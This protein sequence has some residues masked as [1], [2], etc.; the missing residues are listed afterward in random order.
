MSLELIKETI[1]FNQ[2]IGE[3]TVQTI[4]E[5]DIIVP[6]AKP[7]MSRVLLMDGD[8][9]IEDVEVVKDRVVLKGFIYFKI[10]Y[11]TEDPEDCVKS[12]NTKSN[13]TYGMDIIG[14]KPG[15]N[16][17][18]KCDIEHI[19]YDILNSRK[20]SARSIV[21][22]DCKVSNQVEQDIAYDVGGV[23]GVQV[24]RESR[25]ISSY[26]GDNR[27]SF[28]VIE[29]M[30]VPSGKPAIREILR[31]DI[32]ING[33]DYRLTDNK[34]VA[35]GELSVST[36]Y[37]GDDE[38]RSIQFMEHEVPFSQF[39]DL[40]DINEDSWCELDYRIVDFQFEPSE[41]SDG[42]LRIMDGEI[43]LSIS[44]SGYRKTDIDIITD[45][46]SLHSRMS[47]EM[48]DLNLEEVAAENRSQIII[49]DE[50]ELDGDNPQMSE[51]FNVLCRPVL[52]EFKVLEDQI[53]I[54]GLTANNV[55]YLADSAEQPVSC[56]QQE[57][58]FRQVIDAAGVAPGMKCDI[59]MELEH[60]NYSMVSA[61]RVE[62][63]LVVNVYIKSLRPV[64]IPVIIRV[65]EQPADDSR[66][67]A[68]P[69]IIV[70]FS[71]PGDTLWKI[72]KRYYTTIDDIR[73]INDVESDKLAPG[74]QIIITARR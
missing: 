63:R 9:F 66:I 47:L 11:G 15:M 16:C 65:G 74:Q 22:L 44:V 72:A 49:K 28:K 5:S 12:I 1:K 60:C 73:N 45:A 51:I 48:E 67:A 54:E 19:E 70:Y 14:A 25:S 55:L 56:Y 24:L 43:G 68:Q 37:I 29:G 7:D 26:V 64:T 32:K 3:D 2:I 13:F 36:L 8:A 6:D 31:N 30:A 35:S 71:Q 39:I 18:P 46:Y 21:K 33:K 34:I 23:D 52:S 27:A 42:E 4:I 62:I 53:A 41:D 50:I 58:P 69:G 38:N 17:K 59:A 61:N 10:L 40:P 20:I 57:I